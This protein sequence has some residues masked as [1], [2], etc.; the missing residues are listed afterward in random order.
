MYKSQHQWLKA[1]DA[2]E[3]SLKLSTELGLG[4]DEQL[5]AESLAVVYDKL[6]TD[7]LQV[8]LSQE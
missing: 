8:L 1:C 7:K 4:L 5:A 2:Y 6:A 3:A